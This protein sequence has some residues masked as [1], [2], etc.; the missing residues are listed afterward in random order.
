MVICVVPRSGVAGVNTICVPAA[1]TTYVPAM[2]NP[3]DDSY[4][5]TEFASTAHGVIG[6]LILTVT[7]VPPGTLVPRVPAVTNSPSVPL[8]TTL[9]VTIS[10]PI[11]PW[12]VDANSVRV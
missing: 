12:A 11:T 3:V 1:F 8:G 9:T 10:K 6:L 7:V 5:R 2:P 4:T